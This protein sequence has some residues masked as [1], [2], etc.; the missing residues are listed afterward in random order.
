MG[1]DPHFDEGFISA[2]TGRV[3]ALVANV[4]AR[5]AADPSKTE[6]VRVHALRLLYAQA[7]PES[8][9]SYADLIRP[10]DGLPEPG[11]F[12]SDRGPVFG[13]GLDAASAERL[14]EA[15]AAVSKSEHTTPSVRA[16]AG[17]VGEAFR[18]RALQLRACPSGTPA[19]TCL[20]RLRRGT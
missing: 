13:P 8:P 6:A 1:T 12:V 14:A 4:A 2:A 3:D 18:G 17:R 20:E 11:D 19:V 10:W 7:N 16:A 9:L 15:L 5:I